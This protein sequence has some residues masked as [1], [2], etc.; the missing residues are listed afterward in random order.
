MIQYK[1]GK[2]NIITLQ[3]T[4]MIDSYRVE[5]IDDITGKLKIIEDYMGYGEKPNKWYE[6]FLDNNENKAT[7]I[8]EYKNK[9][10]FLGITIYLHNQSAN[11][12]DL[13]DTEEYLKG[14]L[15][16]KGKKVLDNQNRVIFTCSIDEQTNEI[17][18]YPKGR[19]K[20]YY[21][22]NSNDTQGLQ[23]EF[24][25][26]LDSQTNETKVYINDENETS[27][28]FHTMNVDKFIEIFGQ[29]FWDAHPYYHSILPLLPTS[30]NI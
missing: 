4:Q 20:K 5:T 15:S 23:L 12:F 30:A 27:G 9:N 1:N 6:Y 19:P 16:F 8:Q 7:I 22:G 14:E 11:G 28:E 25:Y 3:Q 24:Y 13:W 10:L 18:Q 29:A 2:G 21:Y 26:E 17:I